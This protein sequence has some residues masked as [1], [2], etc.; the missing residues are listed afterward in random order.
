MGLMRSRLVDDNSVSSAD[1]GA[2]KKSYKRLKR[3][4]VNMVNESE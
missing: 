4:R 2:L 3:R 1:E